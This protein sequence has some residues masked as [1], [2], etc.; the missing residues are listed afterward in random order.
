MAIWL[1]ARGAGTGQP[2]IMWPMEKYTDAQLRGDSAA[3]ME[4]MME[5][6]FESAGMILTLITLGKMLEAKSKGRK[7]GCGDQIPRALIHRHT[8]SCEGALVHSAGALLHHPV[9]R[10]LLCTAP[11]PCSP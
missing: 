11:T 3:V 1:W 7:G 10:R 6:Y 5:L 8:L 2:H 9:Q 4:Y